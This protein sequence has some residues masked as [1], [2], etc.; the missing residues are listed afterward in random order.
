[1]IVR[2][3]KLTI[4]PDKIHDFKKLFVSV[5]DS[6]RSFHGCQSLQLLNDVNNPDVFF[7]YS[8][9][10]SENELNDYRFSPFFK[11]TWGKTRQYFSL[12]AEAWS[13]DGASKE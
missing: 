4:Q 9:W 12:P 2:L 3:V 11:N 6:I 10:S 7:T 1:M 13:L 8:V 5:E